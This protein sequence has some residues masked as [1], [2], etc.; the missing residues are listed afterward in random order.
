[1]AKDIILDEEWRQKKFETSR[2]SARLAAGET[3]PEAEDRSTVCRM[4]KIPVGH[5]KWD[6]VGACFPEV[7]GDK[8]YFKCF[9]AGT[10]EDSK[11]F[12]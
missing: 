4:K 3:T 7:T 6:T 1:M 10:K 2:R 5:K 11:E 8:R 12:F 9:C